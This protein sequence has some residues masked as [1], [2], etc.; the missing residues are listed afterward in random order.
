[1]SVMLMVKRVS[2]LQ[3]NNA[4]GTRI[5]NSLSAQNPLRNLP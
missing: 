5:N 1:M 4:T 2:V 3:I